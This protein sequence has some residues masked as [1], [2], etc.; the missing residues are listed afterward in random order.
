MQPVQKSLARAFVDLLPTSPQ[1]TRKSR[2]AFL[3]SCSPWS[4]LGGFSEIGVI[5][6]PSGWNY[7]GG[8]Q[9]I[10]RRLTFLSRTLLVASL[11]VGLSACTR[12]PSESGESGEL[13]PEDDPNDPWNP[14]PSGGPGGPDGPDDPDD[15]DGPGGPDDLDPHQLHYFDDCEAMNQFIYEHGAELLTPQDDPEDWDSG[16]AGG[17]DGDDGG[18][19]FTGGGDEGGGDFGGDGDGDG[20]GAGGDSGG[21]GGGNGEDPDFSMTNVQEDGGRRTRSHQDRR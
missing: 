5:R 15:P 20:D 10:M 6:S 14:G 11:S 8:E 9:A 3:S 1:P 21:A 4:P 12:P 16:E 13:D 18:G 17:W 2:F 19:G 7:E